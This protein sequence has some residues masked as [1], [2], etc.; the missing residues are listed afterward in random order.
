MPRPVLKDTASL[1]PKVAKKR[2]RK[3]A[4]YAR[5]V[6]KS[7]EYHRLW[8]ANNAQ[9]VKKAS[10]AWNKRNP[11]YRD[12][13]L[14]NGWTPERIAESLREQRGCCGICG[15]RFKKNSFAQ[16]MMK[17]HCHETGAARDLLC[18][19]CNLVLG[20]YENNLQGRLLMPAFEEY[21]QKHRARVGL[22]DPV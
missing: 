9:S 15:V 12:R 13:Y 17:D 18:Q 8:R 4:Q 3:R 11:G 2:A 22:T 7:R 6:E 21:I 14:R 1:D 19:T 5:D 16:R 10:D 20:Y